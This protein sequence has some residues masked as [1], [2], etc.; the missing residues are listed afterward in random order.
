MPSDGLKRLELMLPEDH[1][2]W[3]YPKGQWRTKAIEFLEMGLNLEVQLSAINQKL[4]IITEK[5]GFVNIE[6]VQIPE[7]ESKREPEAKSKVVV[8]IAAFAN[9]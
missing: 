3:N 2:I 4:E 7:P 9:I 6:A 1:P 8:D 5:I